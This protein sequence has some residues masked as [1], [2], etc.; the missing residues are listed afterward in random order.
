MIQLLGP[1]ASPQAMSEGIS[2]SLAYTTD[3]I[4]SLLSVCKESS[5]SAARSGRAE[6]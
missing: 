3:G 5:N 6:T 1:I 4:S 2:A